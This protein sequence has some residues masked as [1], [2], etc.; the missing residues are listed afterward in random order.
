[1]ICR[2]ATKG[3][4]IET[5]KGGA[6]RWLVKAAVKLAPPKD[7]ARLFQDGLLGPYVNF[8]DEINPEE[9]VSYTVV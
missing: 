6:A 4:E 5:E 3:I 9:Q 7:V 2:C 1:M 8:P